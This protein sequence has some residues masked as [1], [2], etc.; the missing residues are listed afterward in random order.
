M[1]APVHVLKIEY[2]TFNSSSFEERCQE[3]D[4]SGTL[5]KKEQRSIWVLISA[6]PIISHGT[7]SVRVTQKRERGL[8]RNAFVAVLGY[9]AEF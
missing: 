7:I 9:L 3:G 4:P 1:L 6:L 2:G 8:N 5:E